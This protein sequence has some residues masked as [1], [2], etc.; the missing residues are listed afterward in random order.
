MIDL[1]SLGEDAEKFVDE[2]SSIIRG[3]DVG[4][5]MSADDF[6]IDE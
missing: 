6:I 4:D 1:V 5:S 2:F 3:E